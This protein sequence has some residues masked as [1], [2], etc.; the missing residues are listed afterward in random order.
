[1]WARRA[2]IAMPPRRRPVE[3]LP[4][5]S[6]TAPRHGQDKDMQ[7]RQLGAPPPL[8]PRCSTSQLGA[9]PRDAALWMEQSLDKVMWP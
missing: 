9:R 3:E 7:P 2:S 1:M 4:W 6:A 5:P 8:L